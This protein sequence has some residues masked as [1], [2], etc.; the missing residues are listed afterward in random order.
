MQL[1]FLFET[2]SKS[3]SDYKYVRSYIL[4][5]NLERKFKYSKVYMRGKG[6]FNKQERTINSLIKKYDGESNLKFILDKIIK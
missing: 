4:S 2:N 1:I 5:L 6:N 3:E